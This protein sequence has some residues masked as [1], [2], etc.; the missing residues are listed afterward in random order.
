MKG[1]IL[2]GGNGTR[3]SPFTKI[4]NKHLLPVGPYPMIYWSI[5]KLESSGIKDILIITHQD[6]LKDFKTVLKN[7]ED[8]GVNI[9]YKIQSYAGGIAHGLLYAK[10]FIKKEKFIFMLGDNIFKDSLLPYVKNFI[11]QDE[12]AKILLKNVE[13]PERY[14]IATVNKITNQITSIVEKPQN[15]SSNLCVTGIYMYDD[16]VFG[17]IDHLKT[18]A[19]GELEIT[20][21]NNIYI[22][23]G[24]LSYEVL[25]GW[26]IDAGTHNS[27]FIANQLVFKELNKLRTDDNE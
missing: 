18:S 13:D 16:G 17:Y 11:N 24:K 5:M 15:S 12:G 26:W 19:R 23:K 6:H 20:D 9:T 22:S 1:V 27:L 14:G 8:L 7:G 3:L 2:A 4:I 10:D 21:I 25:Q